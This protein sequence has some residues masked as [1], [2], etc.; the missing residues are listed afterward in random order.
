MST[1]F[2]IDH[3]TGEYIVETDNMYEDF[4]IAVHID[5]EVSYIKPSQV[6]YH[7]P[8]ELLYGN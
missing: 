4:T 8:K 6:I 1:T 3:T 7:E 2:H 5:G